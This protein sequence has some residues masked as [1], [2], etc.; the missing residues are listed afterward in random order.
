MYGI[1]ENAMMDTKNTN[2]PLL[3]RKWYAIIAWPW[4]NDGHLGFFTHNAMFKIFSENTTMYG[5]PEKPHDWHQ[6]HESA[7]IMSKM[8]WIYTLTLNKWRPS[9]T[10]YPQCNVENI[11]WQHHSAGH[12]LKPYNR[13]QKYESAY[14]VLKM[15]SIY[16]L[17]LDK[18]RPS[19][20]SL[21][22]QCLKLFLT[23]PLSR[24]GIPENPI[25]DTKIMKLLLF[26]R[27]LWQF[28]V[29]PSP[30]DGHFEFVRFSQIAQGYPFWYPADM[31]YR[32]H[33]G[34]ESTEK[35]L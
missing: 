19:W 34:V 35:K 25:E 7:S 26:C 14:I 4:T 12:T 23:T 29:L 11:F 16:C 33:E 24:S 30:N 22:M 2:L 6:K 21:T 31:H 20:I 9:W 8:I 15:I 18:W 17:I 3:C 5:I 1:P 10:F 32:Y 27:K 28:K 13:H